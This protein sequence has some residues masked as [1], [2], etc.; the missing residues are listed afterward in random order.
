MAKHSRLQPLPNWIEKITALFVFSFVAFIL[1]KLK[2]TSIS[3]QEY[4]LVLLVIT[5]VAIGWLRFEENRNKQS[6]RYHSGRVSISESGI[7]YDLIEEFKNGR[8][9]PIA[10]IE[11]PSI[12]IEKRWCICNEQKRKFYAI[13]FHTFN[14]MSEIILPIPHIESDGDSL[15]KLNLTLD[16]LRSMK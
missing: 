7:S 12:K 4:L 1:I 9:F 10:N 6:K 3:L 2:P 5:L 16:Q 13:V 14:D 8:F 15:K 11:L